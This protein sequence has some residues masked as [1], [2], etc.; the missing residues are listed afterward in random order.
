MGSCQERI[1]IWNGDTVEDA[2]ENINVFFNYIQAARVDLDIMRFN[3][4]YDG[5]TDRDLASITWD[6]AVKVTETF[7]TDEQK[8]E[9]EAMRKSRNRKKKNRK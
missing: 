1:N 7:G 9:L 8:D 4:A 6:L 5:I 3:K 2:K